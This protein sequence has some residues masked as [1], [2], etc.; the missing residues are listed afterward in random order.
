MAPFDLLDEI[1]ELQSHVTPTQMYQTAHL[2]MYNAMLL[3][4]C[5]ASLCNRAPFVFLFAQ[6]SLLSCLKLQSKEINCICRLCFYLLSSENSVS[7]RIG[8]LQVLKTE[9]GP[10]LQQ[11]RSKNKRR[12]LVVYQDFVLVF[13]NGIQV[14]H[15]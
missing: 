7:D 13:L 8:E 3:T 15:A 9:F 5:L 11:T 2:S 6:G 12:S 10:G 4:L 14:G 1:H